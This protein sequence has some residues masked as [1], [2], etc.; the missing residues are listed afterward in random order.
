MRVVS[1][2]PSATEIVCTLGLQEQ[3]VGISHSCDFPSDI[4]RLPVMTRTTVPKHES[5]EEID[6]HVRRYLG[7]HAAL[8]QLNLDQLEAVSPDVIVSQRLCDVC[9]VSSDDV[10]AAL[11]KLS[12]K[13]LLIDL[14]P[15][16]LA[17]VFADI[18]RVGRALLASGQAEQVVASLEDRISAVAARTETIML[19]QRPRVALLEWLLPPFNSGHW[20]PELVELAGGID[21][22]GPRAKPSHTISWADVL[23]A[24][25]DVVVVSCCGFSRERTTRDFEQLSG[26]EEWQVLLETVDGRIYVTDGNAYFSRPGPRLVDS[27]EAL[28][29]TLHPRIHPQTETDA[30]VVLPDGF[31][32]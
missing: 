16:I 23:Q 13:P 25:P 7:D 20:N 21:C 27:M 5:S 12:S 8:Y 24:R 18:R 14:E 29:H 32:L 31:A 4:T 6:A 3:L 9:A 22:L 10:L 17:D 1:L 28:A 11:N 19:E 2:L 26:L 30:R 15:E